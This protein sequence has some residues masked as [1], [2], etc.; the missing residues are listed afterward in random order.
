VSTTLEVLYLRHNPLDGARIGLT[1]SALSALRELYLDGITTLRLNSSNFNPAVQKT[2][3]LL[4][5]RN[6]Q[7]GDEDLWPTVLSLQG[8]QTLLASGCS[9]TTVPDFAFQRHSALRAIDLSD[10]FLGPV[11][12]SAQ[13]YGL[14]IAGLQSINLDNNWLELIDRCAFDGYP[15][16]SLLQVGLSGNPLRCTDCSMQWLH[17]ALKSVNEIRM[18]FL[19]WTCENRRPFGELSDDDFALCNSSLPSHEMNCTDLDSSLD[20]DQKPND[21]NLLVINVS[22]ENVLLMFVASF[23]LCVQFCRT[24][25]V[26]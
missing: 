24:D 12:T 2:L 25:C 19:T 16:L 9:L 1:F 11:L 3:R 5:V 17:D 14:P 21:G 22:F 8:L 18:S 15:T 26:W 23:F 7:L 10:N 6:T 20:G 13:L 4:S